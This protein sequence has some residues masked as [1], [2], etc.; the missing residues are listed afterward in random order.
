[1][2]KQTFTGTQAQI[3]VQSGSQIE[4][5]IHLDGIIIFDMH[6]VSNLMELSDSTDS[7]SGGDYLLHM[8]P[9]I[10]EALGTVEQYHKI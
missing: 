7:D 5:E 3:I 2:H 6:I 9:N 1:M 10:H 4:T 8:N